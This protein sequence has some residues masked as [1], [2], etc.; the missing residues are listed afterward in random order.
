MKSIEVVAAVLVDDGKILATQRGYGEFEG[1]WEFPGGK[2]EPGEAPE[3]ALAREIHEEMA[4]DIVVERSLCTVEYD[5][6]K[7]HLR[8]QCFVCT[9]ASKFEL[10]EHHAA[11]WVGAA[12]IDTLDWL[13]ADDEVIQAIKREKLV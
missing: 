10:L 6:P 3:A 2:I 8:M 11:K 9:L 1:K 5:Y 12:D 7:F 13:P 4:A